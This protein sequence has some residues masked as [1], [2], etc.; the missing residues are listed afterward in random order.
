MLKRGYRGAGRLRAQFPAFVHVWVHHAAAA[1]HVLGQLILGL[2]LHQEGELENQ[3]LRRRRDH[4]QNRAR[5]RRRKNVL[6]HLHEVLPLVPLGLYLRA[7]QRRLGAHRLA[8]EPGPVHERGDKLEAL[9]LLLRR[10]RQKVLEQSPVVLLLVHSEH[11]NNV[12]WRKPPVHDHE[13]PTLARG[14]ELLHKSLWMSRIARQLRRA[15]AEI[16]R[17]RLRERRRTGDFFLVLQVLFPSHLPGISRVAP[18]DLGAAFY[19]LIVHVGKRVVVAAWI[20]PGTAAMPAIPEWKCHRRN[21]RPRLAD[22]VVVEFVVG[23]RVV[24]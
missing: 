15:L 18:R 24:K 9:V 16:A 5:A 17:N 4:S 14:P 2:P 13:E 20:I 21:L 19:H 7:D 6:R 22:V 12:L 3:L 1:Q 11:E 10:Q 8:D 23:L